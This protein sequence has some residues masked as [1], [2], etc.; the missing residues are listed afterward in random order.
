[1]F[2]V[3]VITSNQSVSSYSV[4]HFSSLARVQ[5]FRLVGVGCALQFVVF[6]GRLSADQAISE[7]LD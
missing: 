1:M 2:T 3:L 7:Y 5:A 4:R 6:P